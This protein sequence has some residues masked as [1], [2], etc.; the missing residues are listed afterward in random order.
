MAEQGWQ[1]RFSVAGVVVDV[2][3]D[4]NACF[5][6]V[7][8]FIKLYRPTE[9]YAVDMRFF[10]SRHDD[11][12]VFRFV[13]HDAEPAVL[14]QSMDAREV[15]AAFE[16][17][18]Y[19]RLIQ[20]LD[21]DK[22]SLHAAVVGVGE[23]AFMFAG[24]SGAGKSSVCTAAVLAGASYFSDEFAILDEHGAL[25]PFPRPMQWEHEFHPAFD[26]EE[27]LKSEK[28]TADF[29]DFPD[30]EGNIA[31]C[32]LWYPVNVQEQPSQISYVFLHRYDASLEQTEIKEVPR[33]EALMELPSHL[34]VQRGM[35]VDLPMLNKRLPDDCR[36]F[37]LG[38]SNVFDAWNAI[39][40]L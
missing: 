2:S 13:E 10:I 26:R 36:F 8:K 4:T 40:L 20:F 31:R 38:Y 34:H 29:F 15:S 3:S 14:W 22:V 11:R 24:D 9:S 16:I 5:E 17:H 18:F 12:Y 39:R 37:R 1:V 30:R 19:T 7:A 6:D 25:I 23:H 32:H 35:S 27:I 21:P 33:Y 28:M